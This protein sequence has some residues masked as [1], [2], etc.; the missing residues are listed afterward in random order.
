MAA[1]SKGQIVKF[2]RNM[3]TKMASTVVSAVVPLIQGIPQSY[4]IE[5]NL[6]GSWTPNDIRVKQ[7]DLDANKTYLF[8]KESELTAI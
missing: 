1:F 4:I 2:D 3:I 7:F 8:V 6:T 5:C